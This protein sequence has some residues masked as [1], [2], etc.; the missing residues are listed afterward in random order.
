[1]T[2]WI[3]VS[4]AFIDIWHPEYLIAFIVYKVNWLRAKAR[5]DR[6]NEEATIVKNEMKWTVLWFRHHERVWTLRAKESQRT[7][8]EGYACYAWKQ[9]DMWNLLASKAEKEFDGLYKI[10]Q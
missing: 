7:E 3:S 9:A 6:W 10:T 2:G 8:K 5:F 4:L 1:M